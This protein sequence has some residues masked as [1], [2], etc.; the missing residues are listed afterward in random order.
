[1]TNEHCNGCGRP[2]G[3]TMMYGGWCE[4]CVLNYMRT[5]GVRS[6]T[7]AA[8]E[9]H[10]GRIEPASPSSFSAGL[11]YAQAVQMILGPEIPDPEQWGQIM[12]VLDD[13]ADRE[14]RMAQMGYREELSPLSP[15]QRE[16]VI[17]QG[18]A[19][20]AHLRHALGLRCPEHAPPVGKPTV[21][22]PDADG[23]YDSTTEYWKDAH[24]YKASD[25][26]EV[27]SLIDKA[28]ST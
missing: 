20:V 6:P 12:R 16:C 8:I 17:C 24:E 1:M 26:D 25:T 5:T 3:E 22:Q 9:L 11:P 18:S 23:Y 21:H 15:A 2:H 27:L 28:L 19:N 13:Q 4:P 10:H 7:Q 14:R